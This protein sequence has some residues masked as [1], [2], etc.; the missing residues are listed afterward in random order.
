MRPDGPGI[1][2][3]DFWRTFGVVIISAGVWQEYFGGSR[4]VV[5]QTLRIENVP[6]TVVGVM[7]ASFHFPNRGIALW[8]PHNIDPGDLWSGNV[9]T[10]IGRL[11][12]GYTVEQA[13]A[14]LRALMPT[15]LE[16]IP[17]RRYVQDYG[18]EADLKPLNESVVGG[19]RRV[20]LVLL[21]AIGVVLLVLCVNVAN[22]LLARGVSRHREMVTRAALGAGRARL[23]RQV[24][25]ES[26]TVSMASGIV[27]VLVSGV[28]M[29]VLVRMLPADFPRIEQI[30]LDLRVLAFALAISAAVGLA[31]SLLPA[32]RATSSGRRLLVRSSDGVLDSR[33]RYVSSVLA[34][35]QFSMAV[36]LATA[37]VLLLQSLWNLTA[38]DPGFR[39]ERLMT[40]RVAPP[41]FTQREPAAKYL[42]AGQ[43]LEAVRAMPAVESAGLASAIPFDQGLFGTVF[44]IEG[45][46]EPAA[47]AGATFLGVTGG[48]F[49]AM[50][51]PVSEG[52]EFTDADGMKSP[53]V[54]MIS[55]RTARKHWGNQSPIGKR[56]RF[57]DQRQFMIG[58][59]GEEP[60]FTVIGIVGDTRFA[61][62]TTDVPP[63][64]YIPLSQFWDLE[65]IR[66]V[67]R[68][69]GTNAVSASQLQ[70]LVSRLDRA[71]PVSDVQ[72]FDARLGETIARPRFAAYLLITFAVVVVFLAAVGTYGVLSHAMNRR[73]PEIG[74]RLAFGASGRHVFGLLFRHGL[75]LTLAGLAVGLPAAAASTRFLSALLFGVEA[76]SAP[77]FAGVSAVLLLVGVCVSYMPARRAR[78]VDPMVALRCE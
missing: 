77:V 31:F 62:L 35:L 25:V 45:R 56:I 64:V 34:T 5:G 1:H 55:A 6:H 41:G 51:I 13:R 9:A 8:F 48:Y 69:A 30:G 78:Q 10:M 38:V 23:A 28:S 17:W 2:G 3:R 63:M 14:E 47:A 61:N 59:D 32:F 73:I 50:G 26:L 37:A 54:A 53:R 74:V 36:V 65:S 40:A 4:D 15:F 75:T 27:G 57:V 66:V 39:T 16:L 68:T 22:L 67:L 7:P 70:G 49:T 19:A 18:R 58:T 76:A 33:E 43:L 42:F 20:L 11:R 44:R 71:T 52:R 24:I 46:T 72:T 21:A 29:R 12:P 60:F